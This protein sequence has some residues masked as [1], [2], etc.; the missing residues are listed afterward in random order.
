MPPFYL[1]GNISQLDDLVD[2]TGAKLIIHCGD[3]GFYG[4]EKKDATR[5]ESWRRYSTISYML[6]QWRLFLTGQIS[7]SLDSF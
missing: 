1:A 2:Q 4:N 6:C 7:L 5:L 3:F